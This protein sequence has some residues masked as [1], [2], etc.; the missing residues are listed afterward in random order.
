M[1]VTV[2]PGKA[3]PHHLEPRA[4]RQHHGAFRH[5]PG[6]RAVVDERPRGADL[7]AVLSPA[8]AV[9]VGFGEGTVGGGL[10]ELDGEA[11]PL[12]PPG[13]HQA[14]PAVAV[15][16]EQVGVDDRDAQGPGHSG[17]ARRSWNA[18]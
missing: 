12:R 5:T 16:A 14:V 9:D 7:G 1:R 18:V 11:A 10:Q 13:Q 8:Q 17:A 4:D 6:E 3:P 15:G 2:G